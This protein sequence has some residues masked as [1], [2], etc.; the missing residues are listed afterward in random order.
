MRQPLLFLCGVNSIG[1][2]NPPGA[3]LGAFFSF[4][5]QQVSKSDEY[6]W[7]KLCGIVATQDSDET[8]ESFERMWKAGQQSEIIKEGAW[9]VGFAG[10]S[11]TVEFLEMAAA[12]RVDAD[13][14]FRAGQE[15]GGHAESAEAQEFRM[16]QAMQ[17]N[18]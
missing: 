16:Q 12:Y 15:E 3:L 14:E 13:S 1:V 5:G 17:G 4:L 6:R 9:N 7:Y 2:Y 11:L 18:Y 10:G 8:N